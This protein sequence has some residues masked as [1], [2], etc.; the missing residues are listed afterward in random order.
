MVGKK[1][2]KALLRD[3]GLERT[4]NNM[5]LSSW[6]QIPPINQKNYYTDYLKRDDQYL[7]FR[8]QNEEARNRM[9]KTAKDRD[10]ALA[11]AKANDLGIPEADADDGDT[12]MEDAE[13]ATAETVGSKVI[14]IHV[15]SQNLRIGLASDA[16]PKT[17]PMVIARKSTTSESEDREEP[18]PKRLKTDDGSELEPEKMFGSEFSSQYT[19]MSA[20]LKTHMRQNKRRTLP[21][22]KEMVINYNRRTVPETISEHNDP[23]R[24]EWTE[25]PDVAPEYI[26]GQAALRIPDESTPRYKLYWPMKYGWCNE[27]DYKSKRL[28]F[29]D[30]SLIIEDAIKNQLGLTSKKDWLQYSCVFVIPDLYEKSYVTQVLE[31]LMREFSFARV[32]FIQESLAATFGAGFT[33]ACVVDIGAQKTSICCVEEGMCIENSRV[34]LKYG[35]SDVTEAFVKMMLYDHF[36]YADINLWR[37][38]DFLLAEE[39]KKNICTMN[40][41]S[42][43]VQVFDFHLRIA[44]QDTR[45]YNFKAY[46]EVHLAP[47]GYFQPSIF[48]HS[49]KLNGRRKLISRSVDIYDGQPNDPTSAAQS[50]LLTAIAPPITGQV[51]GDTLSSTLDVQSTPSRSQQVNALSRLQ[52]AEATPRSSVAGSPAPDVTSTPQAGGAGTPAVGGQSQSTSQ[53][54]APTVEERDDILPTFPLDSAI[55]MSIAHAARS[56]ER[57]MRD[58]LGGIMVVGGGSLINGFHSFLEERLQALRPGFAKEIM[59]GTP[60]RDLDPQV[61][62]WK[63]ASVFGKL[64]G[65]N[66]SWIGQLEY[67]RLGHRLMAYKC[68]MD[69]RTPKLGPIKTKDCDSADRAV[70]DKEISNLI[71]SPPLIFPLCIETQAL[72]T[73]D[74]GSSNM[75]KTKDGSS[76]GGFHQEY[77]ASLRYRNDLPPPDMP[78]KFL[79]IPHDG[80]ERF[81]TP[82]FASNLARREEPNIDVDAEGGM[83]ID[84][85]GIPGLHLGDESAI[86]APENPDPIDPADLP[87]LMT[88]DQLK[89]P[90]PRNTNVS[91]LR[92]TQYI[93]AGLRAPEGPKVTPMRSKSRQ[94]E[95]AKSQDDPAYIKKYI[96]KGFDIAYP[97][98]KHAGEDTPS[99]IKGHM[100]TKLEVDAWATPVHPDNPKLKPVGFYP[101]MPDL[102]GFPDPGGFVQFKFD[103]A[104]IQDVSGKR[105][106]RIDTG[107]L[108]PSAPEERVCEEHATKVALHKTNPKLYPDP[109]PIP[110]D[111]DLFLPEKK[112]SIKKVLASMQIY[113]PDRDNEELY[114]H[115]GSDNSKFHRFDRM[116]TFATSA[117]TLGGD[118]KQKDIAVTL[119]DPS[120]AKEDY[121]SSKQKAAYY[122]P[123]LGKTRLKPERA[124]TI[125]QAGLAPTRPKTKEDQ[126]D[127]IQV[128]VRDPDEM[129]VYKRSLHRAAID[130]KFAKTMPPPPEAANDEHESPEEGDKEAVSGDREQSVEEA[131][132]MS[133]E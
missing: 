122:Y 10:R 47:M 132:R 108:L 32:C 31:M 49:L 119:F 85:V 70:S 91:F 3:E 9:T 115:E 68:I 99:Q 101:L 100:P 45:K 72:E 102:Q 104:P 36:P 37:R 77:I 81:L 131:D 23:M 120:E 34:N 13:E 123:I 127:Q 114:T 21:N 61:V 76:S 111:Y 15:G 42:V 89:N 6:P 22:S 53:P 117:Q 103:K 112:D 78:P 84:L 41:A 14:V 44:G 94:A 107:I 35:G 52:E 17:I 130:P 7:A 133:D 57:K 25:I 113:N 83:P 74:S 69:P 124:R 65:T 109:G 12:N 54:R 43:S 110:W 105:D 2:G 55:L 90:A 92:R 80:L 39:L 1:S 58:F 96:Q 88:L 79:D 16:L 38:Y 11:M 51:N 56:D 27:R 5:E 26:V 30:I 62:V 33:S 63:G 87:L 4:D 46:D 121:L 97:D 106:R 19:T 82:G 116:R 60:P 29:L 93:S 126:V 66:D 18:C 129:E 118:N 98:S 20:E 59:I 67:D 40:E 71:L 75:S 50:E 86:M 28:L 8:L 125:A 24:V 128:V 95:K 73:A 64:S 48:D